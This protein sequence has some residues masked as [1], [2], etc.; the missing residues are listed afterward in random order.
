MAPTNPQLLSE[1]LDQ[2]AQ[3][4]KEHKIDLWI[5]F[6]RETMLMRDPSFPLVCPFDMVWQSAFLI[7]RKGD[8]I[9]VVGRYDIENLKRKGAYSEIIP[10]DESIRPALIAAI[11][12]AKPKRIAIN[13]SEG[14]PAADG[15]THGMHALLMGILSEAGFAKNVES[16]EA[17]LNSLR[18]QKTASEIAR[19]RRAIRT[20][21]KLYREIGK[22]I[23]TGQTEQQL[24]SKLHERVR[25]LNLGTAWDRD[26]CPAVNTGPD[27][28]IG[29]AGPGKLR[30]K[31]GHLL[32]FDFGVLQDDYCSDLQRNWYLLEQDERRP[33]E[34]VRHAWKVARGALLAGAEAMRPGVH[35]WEVDAAA[36][37]YMIAQGFPEYMHAFGHHIGRSAHDGATT[38]GPRWDRYGNTPYGIL[39]VGNCFAIELGVFV[40]GRGYIYLEENVLVTESG[41]EWLSKPQKQLWLVN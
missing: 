23:K 5:T 32:H 7:T 26:F 35:G 30:T 16:A 39:E 12:K 33:P 22:E 15:L 2:A 38:L 20:T 8:R 10:Y 36:R 25:E 41:I 19:I 13:T 34:E 11:N 24:A 18:G 27:T 29:H 3:L 14:D 9:A 28:A 37:A 40:M 17:F 6:V 31:R 21:E 1:K 4:L